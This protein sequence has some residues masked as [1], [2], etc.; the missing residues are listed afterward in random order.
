MAKVPF[1]KL[2]IK[3][4]SSVS[5]ILHG[6]QEIEVKNYIPFTTKV[7]IV[8]NV[9]NN[10]VD[11]NSFYNPMRV[12]LYLALEIIAECTNIS[13]T[14]KQ[15]EDPFKLYDMLVSSGLVTHIRNLIAS[16][17]NDIETNVWATIKNIYDYKNSA[18][19]ILDAV[20]TDYSDLNLDAQNIQK[21]LGDPN[22]LTLLKDVMTK[23]G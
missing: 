2:G 7:N 18:M 1:S 17:W 16:E 22:N 9:I 8:S 6:D 23:L 4:D 10:S 21:A 20:S 5:T 13:F 14:A 11:E 12:Q 19:G 3:I 15:S